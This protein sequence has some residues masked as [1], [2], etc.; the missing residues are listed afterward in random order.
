MDNLNLL[1]KQ[2][3]LGKDF[4]AYGTLEKPLFLAKDV[5]EWIE[6]SNPRM[7]LQSVDEDEKLCVNNPYASQGQQEQWFLTENGLYEVLMVS[8]K[9]I[10]KQF[11]KEVK[12]LLH[13]LRLNKITITPAKSQQ[14]LDNE[15]DRNKIA[16][17][18]IYLNLA[19]QYESNPDYKQILNAYATKALEDKFILPLPKL[20]ETNYS[21]TEVGEKL[22][23][24][25]NKVGSIAKKLNLKND[26][27]FGKWY[28]SK[29]QYSNKEVNTF[30]YSDKAIN[31]IR[32]EL[33]KERA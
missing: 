31:L 7:M 12:K 26:G 8:R 2:K 13:N 32:R 15:T 11:K 6:H 20:E 22:G 5:A 25:A 1:T 9:P 27:E 28:I 30:R 19:K 3:I 24:S 10:A 17:A 23:I 29:S 4:V 33:T 14:E 18:N 16:K 21:A